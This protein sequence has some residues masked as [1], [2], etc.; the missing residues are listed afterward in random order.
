MSTLK[1][2]QV[3]ILPT[4]EKA[5]LYIIKDKLYIEN[6][7]VKSVNSG[8]QHIYFLLDEEIEELPK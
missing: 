7:P 5:S 8:N 6:Y 2:C 4:N 3:V 1:K